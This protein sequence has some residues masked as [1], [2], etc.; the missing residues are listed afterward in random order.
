MHSLINIFKA[1]FL[2]LITS[3]KNAYNFT[4]LFKS[5]IWPF[6]DKFYFTSSLISSWAS[7]CKAKKYREWYD[8]KAVVSVPVKNRVINY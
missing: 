8:N 3:F 1:G 2:T 5:S 4:N 6:L 7:G